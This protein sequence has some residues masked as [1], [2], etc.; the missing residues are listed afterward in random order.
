MYI[1]S[2]YSR[3]W[4]NLVIFEGLNQVSGERLQQFEVC[5]VEPTNERATRGAR[6]CIFEVQTRGAW[7]DRQLLAGLSRLPVGP[8]LVESRCGAVAVG[9]ACLFPS[10]SSDDA[11]VA[12][13]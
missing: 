1:S 5:R 13:P 7:F 4:R 9:L 2:S 10:L 12:L 8:K 3:R 11:R 6:S